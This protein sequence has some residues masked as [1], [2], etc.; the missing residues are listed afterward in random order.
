MAIRKQIIWDKKS[1]QFLGHC[2]YGDQFNIEG[3]ETPATEA[4]VFML[5]GLNGKW[6][7]PIGYFFINKINSTTLAELIKSALIL[8]SNVGLQVQ[9]VTCD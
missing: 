1:N 6:K 8:T 2:D 9:S 5:I 3:P 4:L 7:W